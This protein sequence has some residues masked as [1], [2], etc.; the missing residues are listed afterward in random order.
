MSGFSCSFMNGQ[1]LHCASGE[2]VSPGSWSKLRSKPKL[3]SRFDVNLRQEESSELFKKYKHSTCTYYD[4]NPS[5]A[6][7]LLKRD[8]INK[9]LYGLK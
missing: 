1:S 7:Q 3:S 4:I 8:S 9:Y 2:K 6:R 5:L